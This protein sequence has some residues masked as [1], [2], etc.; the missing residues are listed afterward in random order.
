MGIEYTVAGKD[1][2]P[3]VRVAEEQ[4]SLFSIWVPRVTIGFCVILL[5]YFTQRTYRFSGAYDETFLDPANLN[6]V[7]GPWA[8]EM[9]YKRGDL[10]YE[11]ESLFSATAEVE[12]STEAI[13]VPPAP[14]S[15]ATDTLESAS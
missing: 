11:G 12:A 8:K 13:E 6:L 5:I 7:R 15:E 14:P 2:D 4:E 9:Y 10:G 1:Q 3:I